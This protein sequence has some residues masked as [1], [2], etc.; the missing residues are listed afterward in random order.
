[1]RHADSGILER[2]TKAGLAFAKGLGL[3]IL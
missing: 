3:R 2:V 1:V